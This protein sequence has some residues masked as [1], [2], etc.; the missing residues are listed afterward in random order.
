MRSFTGF[1]VL[2]LIGFIQ[3][4]AIR[5]NYD[6]IQDTQTDEVSWKQLKEQIK[7]GEKGAPQPSFKFYANEKF[8]VIPPVEQFK[9]P[10]PSSVKD[11]IPAYGDPVP[12]DL[13]GLDKEQ[14][15]ENWWVE[16]WQE[17]GQTPESE[18]DQKPEVK[19]EMWEENW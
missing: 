10:S 12:E 5:K 8:Q 18:A 4:G 9:Q 11:V 16:N 15:G 14:T 13:S 17:P 1:L 3:I 6:P 7:D 19:E 2:C